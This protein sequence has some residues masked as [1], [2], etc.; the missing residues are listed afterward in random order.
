MFELFPS[1][2]A[3]RVQIPSPAPNHR[4][5]AGDTTPPGGRVGRVKPRWRP[6]PPARA[7]SPSLAPLEAA[8]PGRWRL[9]LR[10]DGGSGPVRG[11]FAAKLKRIREGIA[12]IYQRRFVVMVNR[13]R[14]SALA[15]IM[16]RLPRRLAS[17]SVQS[18]IFRLLQ[19]TTG[20]GHMQIDASHRSGANEADRLFLVTA[21][22]QVGKPAACA[23]LLY[24]KLECGFR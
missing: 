21:R 7:R 12:Q 23:I 9:I 19:P 18:E 13:K 3:R 15:K 10:D 1:T 6:A 8:S 16:H 11:D 14:Q 4:L 2:D 5:Q 22:L 17:I 20:R 24:R